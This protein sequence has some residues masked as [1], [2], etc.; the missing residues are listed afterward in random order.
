MT[1]EQALHALDGDGIM[2]R[3][4]QFMNEGG[5]GKMDE[6]FMRDSHTQNH[7]QVPTETAK[8]IIPHLQHYTRFGQDRWYQPTLAKYKKL[9]GEITLSMKHWKPYPETSDT[10][11]GNKIILSQNDRV[12]CIGRTKDDRFIISEECDA[13]FGAEYDKA[14]MLE[15]I[16]ELRQ[17]VEATP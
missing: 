3:I 17:W 6:Y 10:P 4:E 1:P 7:V 9:I 12:V 2:W 5:N 8:A 11:I 14:E 13:C 16:D 15:L